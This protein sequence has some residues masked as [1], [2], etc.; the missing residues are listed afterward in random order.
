MSVTLT[1]GPGRTSVSGPG[2]AHQ[3]V[4]E[5]LAYRV[6]NW[7]FTPKGKR[8]R[9]VQRLEA[10]LA[11]AR[12]GQD[13]GAIQDLQ[14]AIAG[15]KAQGIWDGWS[16]AYDLGCHDLPTGLVP[17][18]VEALEAAGHA[19]L[20]Q[21][22][23]PAAPPVF[24]WPTELGLRDYQ[25]EAVQAGIEFRRG[26]IQMATGAGK[27]NVAAG[28]ASR[29]RTSTLFLVHTRD[30]LYQAIERFAGLFYAGDEQRVGQIGDGQVRL[31]PI[32][33]GTMQAVCAG[34]GEK[35][36]AADDE[37]GRDSKALKAGKGFVEYWGA[38]PGQ[39]FAAWPH[40]VTM[41]VSPQAA[42]R[43]AVEHCGMVIADEAQH[44]SCA[45]L[46]A[47]LGRCK[48]AGY[49]LGLSATPWRDDGLDLLM[50]GALADIVYRKSA[51]ELIRAGWLLAP[52]I[53][54]IPVPAVDYKE[55]LYAAAYKREVV[56]HGE[57]NA[58]VVELAQGPG[59]TLVLVK[60]IEHGGQLAARIPCAAYLT[61]KDTSD[62]RRQ[63]LR[64]MRSGALRCLVATSLA[65]EGLDL[66]GLDTL[67][68]AG[69]GKSTTR[70]LQRVGRVIRV[71]PQNPGKQPRVYDFADEHPLL[72]RHSTARLNTYRM[73]PA[74]HV[75]EA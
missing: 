27:T 32:T 58:K 46:Q 41:C 70:A 10:D 54:M 7:L 29:A 73:E 40:P 16:N 72:A 8:Y 21:N 64:D 48:D 9:Q 11:A 34:L 47:I 15:L 30:L 5:V 22:N 51:T 18:V 63:I 56:D 74:F 23:L 57:R 44:C 59:R 68:L 71:D 42:V 2:A 39:G 36:E 38:E 33:V 65:D 28:L 62:K 25:M 1:I 61:G 12:Q 20:L 17:R 4:R 52:R 3:V 26:I 67:V 31:R 75:I 19:C 66:P 43:A 69:G 13:V 53:E 24:D 55:K 60:Q 49:V 14:S 6:P 50:E 45:T 35:Y 37:G